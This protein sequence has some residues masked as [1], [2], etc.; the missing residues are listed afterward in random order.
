MP[1][2]TFRQSAIGPALAIDLA[3]MRCRQQTKLSVSTT[4]QVAHVAEA[5]PN[6]APT[7]SVP[8]IVQVLLCCASQRI[9]P[10]LP[11]IV[12]SSLPRH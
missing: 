4:D 1:V 12:P 5:T 11:S 7:A 6:A 8:L 3:L 10:A 2:C 9:E